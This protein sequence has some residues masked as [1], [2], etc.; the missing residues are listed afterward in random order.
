MLN[1]A[2]L[3]G[4]SMLMGQTRIEVLGVSP[5]R[6]QFLLQAGGEDRVLFAGVGQT[7]EIEGGTIIVRAL[8]PGRVHIGIDAPR[9]L[10]VVREEAREKGNGE[11]SR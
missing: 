11:G 10:R 6:V 2:R 5:D 1:L 4:Q 7:L 9:T 3:V 8:F